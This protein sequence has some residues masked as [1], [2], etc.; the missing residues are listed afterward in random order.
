MATSQ[1]SQVIERLRR[2]VLLRDAGGLP[3]EKLLES[4]ISRTSQSGKVTTGDE[5]AAITESSANGLDKTEPQSAT[6]RL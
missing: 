4:F 6:L 2:L 5:S 3:D 1:L